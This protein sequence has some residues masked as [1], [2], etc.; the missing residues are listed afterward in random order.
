MFIHFKE[1]TSCHI[2]S[3]KIIY[4]QQKNYQTWLLSPNLSVMKKTSNFIY[5]SD[6]IS[7]SII[8][9]RKQ[10]WLTL[11]DIL[12][13]AD[14]GKNKYH[15]LKNTLILFRYNFYL[16]FRHL[17]KQSNQLIFRTE[18]TSKYSC[19][20]FEKSQ[21]HTTKDPEINRTRNKQTRKELGTPSK[22]F[23]TPLSRLFQKILLK[24]IH[25]QTKFAPSRLRQAGQYI[26]NVITEW[27]ITSKY[28][29]T[30]LADCPIA[31]YKQNNKKY[32]RQAT[33]KNYNTKR[34]KFA[35]I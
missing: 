13:N 6:L 15:H 14:R 33:T 18:Q 8:F 3:A 27:L 29:I 5:S 25:Q 19:Y 32:T 12:V 9:R 26:Q 30:I 21:L 2:Y 34:H 23:V 22:L 24:Q 4:N 11:S 1:A 20:S 35:P 7:G 28:G 10:K 17:L 31:D 16:F